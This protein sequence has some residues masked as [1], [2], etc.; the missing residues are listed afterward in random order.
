MRN[1]LHILR[2]RQGVTLIEAMVAT[3]IV[4]LVI[5]GSGSI[6]YRS[7]NVQRDSERYS[8][9]NNLARQRIEQL[10]NLSYASIPVGTTT[11]N[12]AGGQFR[13]TTTVTNDLDSL[14]RPKRTKTIVVQ[15]QEITG[16][17]AILATHRTTIYMR[18]I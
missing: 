8:F 11:V 1:A 2:K 13:I 16:R 3:V 4:T 15:V 14:G 17:Q 5:L 9:A 7:V 12:S 10:K 6:F 18:G